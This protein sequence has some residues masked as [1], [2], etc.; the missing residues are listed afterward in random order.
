MTWSS[1][2]LLMP[3]AYRNMV[4][5][6]VLEIS[7]KFQ[8]SKKTVENV[9]WGWNRGFIRC[10]RK[11]TDGSRGKL[12]L[13]ASSHDNRLISFSNFFSTIRR[14]C[15][16]FLPNVHTFDCLQLIFYQDEFKV[17]LNTEELMCLPLVTWSSVAFVSPKANNKKIQAAVLIISL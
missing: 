6:V 1:I 14:P 2:A 5:I 4:Q 13:R 17:W 10:L 9:Q 15:L 3:N 8:L 16:I 7:R 11:R 12:I